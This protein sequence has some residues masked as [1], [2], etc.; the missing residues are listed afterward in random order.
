MR[1]IKK[2]KLK[3]PETVVTSGRTVQILKNKTEAVPTKFYPRAAVW[4]EKKFGK[5][6]I[7]IETLIEKIALAERAWEVMELAYNRK[8]AQEVEEGGSV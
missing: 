2:P 5:D 4:T 1:M 8:D 6:A 3:E 7:R